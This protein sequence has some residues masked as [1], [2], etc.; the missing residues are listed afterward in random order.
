MDEYKH[1]SK[2]KAEFD[3]L[4]RYLRACEKKKNEQSVESI[5]RQETIV[6][7][8]DFAKELLQE[9]KINFDTYLKIRHLVLN[10]DAK[11]VFEE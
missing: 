8:V 7:G 4:I 11:Y 2:V 10:P 3:A 1:K 9:G 5:L 6:G